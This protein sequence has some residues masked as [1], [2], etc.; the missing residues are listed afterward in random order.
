MSFL[1]DGFGTI[2]A[3]K[4]TLLGVSGLAQGSLVVWDGTELVNVPVGADGEVLTADSTSPSGLSYQPGGGGQPV[5]P[6]V[7]MYMAIV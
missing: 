1:T 2:M 3:N 5:E 6:F 7:L 4:E